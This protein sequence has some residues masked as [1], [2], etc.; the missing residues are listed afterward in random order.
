ML[1]QTAGSASRRGIKTLDA[2][3]F[4]FCVVL[5]GPTMSTETKAYWD[6][7]ATVELT[8]F[9]VLEGKS[10]RVDE[11]MEY[12]RQHLPEALLS[13]EEEKMFV[14][15]IFRETIGSSE[16]LYWYSIQGQTMHNVRNS[17]HEIDKKH[18]EYWD[19]CIGRGA[20]RETLLTQVVMVPQ[21]LQDQM[22]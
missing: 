19:E 14:E 20:P 13:L 2:M 12:L 10:A 16:Y 15:T 22:K 9:R 3:D 17:S 21:R 1:L 11:W 5:E 7:P 4:G 18:M 6:H 8:R